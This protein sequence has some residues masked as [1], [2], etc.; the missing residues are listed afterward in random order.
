MPHSRQLSHCQLCLTPYSPDRLQLGQPCW[1]T[2]HLCTAPSNLLCLLLCVHVLL[3]AVALADALAQLQQRSLAHVDLH[4]R[5]PR[6]LLLISW[7]RVNATRHFVTLTNISGRSLQAA[8]SDLQQTACTTCK[9]Y[10]NGCCG[11]VLERTMQRPGHCAEE[12]LNLRHALP[13]A[14]LWHACTLACRTPR[15][16]KSA[17]HAHLAVTNLAV[18]TFAVLQGLKGRH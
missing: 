2:S 6:K 4:N 8:D 9:I 15:L 5:T 3:V 11:A 18:T 10:S 13:Q 16:V 7:A 1:L 12:R 14:V 17:V